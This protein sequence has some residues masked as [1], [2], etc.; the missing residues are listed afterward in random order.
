[1]TARFVDTKVLLYAVSTDAAEQRKAAIARELLNDR[2]LVLS[3]QV[4]QEFYVQATRSSRAHRLAHAQA[5]ALVEAFT[6]FRVIDNTP[7]I[8]TQA[9]AT[10]ERWGISFWDAA[11][12]EAAR[13]ARCGE[14]LS[15]DLADGQDY[16]GVVVRNPF[17]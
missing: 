11:I 6:R 9:M 10:R 2:Q 1:M 12:I 8:L 4:L 3:V 5:A 13:A 14:L 7:A 16:D 15:E 17:S